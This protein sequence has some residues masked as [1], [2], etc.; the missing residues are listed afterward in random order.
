MADHRSDRAI[1]AE[2]NEQQPEAVAFPPIP[3]GSTFAGDNEI[4][5]SIS[6][7]DGLPLDDCP[8][9]DNANYA[10]NYRAQL[11]RGALELNNRPTAL[12]H[13]GPQHLF[14]ETPRE[15]ALTSKLMLW[16]GYTGIVSFEDTFTSDFTIHNGPANSSTDVDFLRSFHVP[17]HVQHGLVEATVF[18]FLAP[19]NSPNRERVPTA[20]EVLHAL[21]CDDAFH[22]EK[23]TV[24]ILQ[25]RSTVIAYP[26]EQEERKRCD[27]IHTDPKQQYVFSKLRDVH[28]ARGQKRLSRIVGVSFDAHQTLREY[29]M[30]GRLYYC[31]V[32]CH[33]EY[34][35]Q[36]GNIYLGDT[37]YL[38]VVGVSP[39]SGNL[40]GVFSARHATDLTDSY[41]AR[42]R[43]H[44]KEE[45]ALTTNE[46]DAEVDDQAEPKLDSESLR[47]DPLPDASAD[48]EPQYVFVET[49]DESVLSARLMLWGGY[50]GVV[51]FEGM[52]T[53]A[54][55]VIN[56]DDASS[57]NRD[58]E[59]L[60][61]YEAPPSMSKGSMTS[62]VYKFVC[63][64]PGTQYKERMPSG[65]ELIRELRNEAHFKSGSQTAEV[66]GRTQIPYP[67]QRH[68]HDD[69]VH[70]DREEQ[71]I[72]C[73]EGD[74]EEEEEEEEGKDSF[75]DVTKLS[76]EAHR[77]LEKYVRKERLYYAV[78]HTKR[79]TKYDEPMSDYV[80]AFA[81]GVSP[82]S[83][84]LV[85][86]F[87][88]QV[89]HNLTS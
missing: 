62:A 72:F 19:G 46:V 21:H 27:E 1:N 57:S 68:E 36:P 4:W 49:R 31:A 45:T 50:S 71:Y 29:V 81:V 23:Q 20:M 80:Y 55:T 3:E 14:S 58:L 22:S 13:N 77:N 15:S 56:G 75:N 32:H 17:T 16:G 6:N 65:T 59:F 2:E 63:V 67:P 9:D 38:F 87:S 70:T 8:D 86:V 66:L 69:E 28:F 30:D 43:R 64:I 88:P 39:H 48:G 34:N 10:E 5:P 37:V 41:F 89:S 51:S 73:V 11:H 79:H 85:G 12:E 84:N 35:V 25:Q 44:G 33:E 82:H 18:R 40:V 76:M 24:E 60:H 7:D 74:L 26:V 52:L 42:E 61:G 47:A 83:G 78:F 53:D 54:N